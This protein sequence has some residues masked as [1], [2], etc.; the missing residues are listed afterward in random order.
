MVPFLFFNFY[1]LS[2]FSSRGLA[3][4]KIVDV[5][6]VSAIALTGSLTVRGCSF[7]FGLPDVSRSMKK[8][9][10]SHKISIKME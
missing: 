2:I 5:W 1:I 8:P 9:T 4:P 6:D 7:S 10:V 3:P